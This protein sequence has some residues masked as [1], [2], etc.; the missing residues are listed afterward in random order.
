[1]NHDKPITA[2][3]LRRRAEDLLAKAPEA[4]QPEDLKDVKQLAHELAVH[5]AELELQNEELR[6]TQA[7]LQQTRE[8]F[9][10]LYDRAPVGYVV[11]DA[12]GIIRQTN[13]TWG[14]MLRRPDEDFRG[15]AFAET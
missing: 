4:F 12:S 10:S 2:D 9:A 5:Q 6:D 11:L 15:K 13:A 7:A 14:A 1:M 3:D 8:G